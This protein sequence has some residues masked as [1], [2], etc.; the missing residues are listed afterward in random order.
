MTKI[1]IYSTILHLHNLI[2]DHFVEKNEITD[3]HRSYKESGYYG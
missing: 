2:K 3:K 1:E